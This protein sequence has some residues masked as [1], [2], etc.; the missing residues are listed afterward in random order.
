MYNIILVYFPKLFYRSSLRPR[1][2]EP[3]LSTFARKKLRTIYKVVYLGYKTVLYSN[4]DRI[5]QTAF[6]NLSGAS[7]EKDRVVMQCGGVKK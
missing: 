5:T 4:G 6:S 1:A 2:V 7:R 3:A